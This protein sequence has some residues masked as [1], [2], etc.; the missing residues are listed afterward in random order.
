MATD[1][2]R[3]CVGTANQQFRVTWP[4]TNLRFFGT[5]DK[6]LC[7]SSSGSESPLPFPAQSLLERLGFP[8][9]Y[10]SASLTAV[11]GDSQV[12]LTDGRDA[13]LML[14]EEAV[15]L[16]QAPGVTNGLWDRSDYTHLKINGTSESSPDGGGISMTS[17][18]L[19]YA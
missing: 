3:D 19:V 14:C 2:S 8:S 5:A 6:E 7:V 11:P 9:V 16:D 10:S 13:L 18:P 17:P 12:D 15:N 1:A 4:T